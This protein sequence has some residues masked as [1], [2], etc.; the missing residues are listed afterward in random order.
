M[1]A[2]AEEISSSDYGP[3]DLRLSA[4][5]SLRWIDD[6]MKVAVCMTFLMLSSFVTSKSRTRRPMIRYPK[7]SQFWATDFFVRGC[8]NFLESCP[9]EY[10]YQIICARNYNGDFKFFPNYCEM[11]YENCNTWQNWHV[12]KRERC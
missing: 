9:K 10:K 12:F 7:D 2:G 5:P 3:E 11:Q 4:G 8:K 6:L 1:A